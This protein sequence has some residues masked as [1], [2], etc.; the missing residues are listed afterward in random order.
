MAAALNVTEPTST[1]IGGDAFCHFYDARTKKV[2]CLQGNGATSEHFSLKL[3]NERGIGMANQGMV[4]L[5]LKSGLC[6]T[7][8]GSAMLWEDAVKEFGCLSLQ[9]VL[10][11]AIKLAREGFPVSPV[12]AYQWA[13]TFNFIQGNESHR[14][15]HFLMVLL[16]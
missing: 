16:K 10:E 1:G 6:V 3:L 7:V 4:P 5:E 12:A 15:F 9:E 13:Y 11:P 14:I 8:P 2:T